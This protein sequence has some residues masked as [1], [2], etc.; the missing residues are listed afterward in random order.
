MPGFVS[1][2]LARL[3]GT[4]TVSSPLYPQNIGPGGGVSQVP[5]DRWAAGR[6]GIGTRVAALYGHPDALLAPTEIQRLFSGE[7][8]P[9]TSTWIDAFQYN[10]INET[11]GT[12]YTRLQR[13]KTYGPTLIGPAEMVALASAPSK[14]HTLNKIWKRARGSP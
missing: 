3:Y 2:L 8:V 6:Q 1:K 13:G 11:S 9:V 10:L 7:W 5:L 4:Q 14:G 12:L